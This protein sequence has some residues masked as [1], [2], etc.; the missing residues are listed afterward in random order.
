MDG[1]W[2][3]VLIVAIVMFAVV[4]KSRYRYLDKQSS[5]SAPQQRV[6]NARLEEEVKA[7]KQRIQ[8]LER[9]AVDKEH[10]LAREIEELRDR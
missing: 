8:T 1:N 9:I 4:M 2:V 3:P 7:L 10:S 6:E 5:D